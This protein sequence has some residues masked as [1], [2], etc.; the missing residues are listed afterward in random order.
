M[1]VIM[2]SHNSGRSTP[3]TPST[4]SPGP[5][6]LSRTHSLS[7]ETPPTTPTLG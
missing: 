6:H 1:P 7:T 2:S 3:S 5:A 4:I